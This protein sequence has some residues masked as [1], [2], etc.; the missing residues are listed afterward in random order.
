MDLQLTEEQKLVSETFSRLFREHSTTSV[1][2]K[3]EPLGFDNALWQML[4]A[5]DV[6][7][8]RVGE[9]HGGLAM[10]LRDV[11]VIARHAGYHI[12]PVPLIETIIC[13]RML[14]DIGGSVALE[15]FDRI[16]AGTAIVSLACVTVPDASRQIVS[17]GGIAD[18]VIAFDGRELALFTGPAAKGEFRVNLGSLPISTWDFTKSERV[19]LADGDAAR[20]AYEAALEE[21]KLLLAAQ[22]CGVCARSLE[23]A[24]EY[25]REREAFGVKIG[26]FQGL[27]HPLAECAIANDGTQL[28]I[29]FA[30]WK[31]EQ[32]HA[33]AHAYIS[34]AYWWA[35]ETATMT[36]PRCV[37]VF[38]GYGVAVEHDIQLFARRGMA[39]TAVLGDRQQE[40]LNIARRLW[41]GSCVSTP[42]AGSN[43][44]DFSL[45]AAAES[46]LARVKQF[47]NEN[48]TKDLEPFRSHSWDGF[49]PS[50]YKKLAAENLLFPQWPKDWG[51]LEASPSEQLAIT[52]AFYECRW[53][54]YPQGTSGMV[55]EMI[56]KFGSD[57]LKREVLPLIKSGDAIC[58]LGFTEPHC[59]SD[60]FSARTRATRIGSKWVING[61]KMFTSGANIAKYVL[62][63]TNTNPEASKHVGKTLF[64][65]PMDLP[66]IEIQRINTISGD[67]THITYYSDVVIDDKYR[68]GDVD[69][70]ASVMGYMLSLEQGGFP[71]GFEFKHMVDQA[72]NWA[73]KTRR[74]R[75]RIFDDPLVQV[76]LAAAKTDLTIAE[77]MLL[78]ITEQ[79][80]K[81][82]NVR[83]FG[84][85]LKAFVCEAWKKHGAS[86]IGMTAPY[87][88]ISNTDDLS[89]IEGGWRSSLAS[90]VYGGTTQV[91]LS[92][93][94][95]KALGMPRSR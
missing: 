55:G 79:R 84:S 42:D 47:F 26:T 14:S 22:L 78:R 62:L 11:T 17:C 52:Q 87:S 49:H 85:M 90:A 19:F 45:G 73:L 71:S 30:I 82:I 34:M 93:V 31:L 69:S 4:V 23:Y 46:M 48:I 32:R 25:S 64:L 16:M 21:W 74:N 68:L 88:L 40:L 37:H 20:A 66:G 27:S 5:L 54:E 70:G 80:E 83:H 13:A 50:V 92:I 44:I 3:S 18:A 58:C 91:H 41:D 81:G 76:R 94:A 60:V 63:L 75:R 28:L 10:G 86:L 1:V 7:G 77:L 12:A 9:T 24:A 38:G 59:G 8:A 57:E 95:E 53:T 15:W 2:R 36:L 39:M 67:L 33:D 6:P 43:S 35:T 61:Q 65:V 72:V 56:H 51:G 29:D 89:Y